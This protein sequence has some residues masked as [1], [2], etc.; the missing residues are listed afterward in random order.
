[1]QTNKSNNKDFQMTR[2]P[3][4]LFQNVFNFNV[5]LYVKVEQKRYLPN[6]KY[7]L[8]SPLKFREKTF[9]H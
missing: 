6:S 2:S 4:V 7:I 5:P 9:K 1:M 3:E 8:K